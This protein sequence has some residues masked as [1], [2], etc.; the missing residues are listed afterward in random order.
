M[1]SNTSFKISTFNI[2]IF[3]SRVPPNLATHILKFIYPFTNYC[4]V[5]LLRRRCDIVHKY[6]LW[7]SMLLKLL[8]LNTSALYFFQIM[9]SYM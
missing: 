5:Y 2:Q 1:Q 7:H 8:S 3:K 4:L 6:I 9:F